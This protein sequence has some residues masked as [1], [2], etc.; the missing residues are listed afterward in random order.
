ML[1]DCGVELDKN[2]IYNYIRRMDADEFIGGAC[3]F[4]EARVEAMDD[5]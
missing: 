1:L 3:G 4:M 2:A 5:F